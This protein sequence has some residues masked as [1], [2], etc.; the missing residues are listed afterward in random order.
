MNFSI[1]VDHPIVELGAEKSFFPRVSLQGNTLFR[2]TTAHV[3]GPKMSDGSE[4]DVR[5]WNFRLE[6]K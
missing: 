5:T 6:S 1:G 2:A 4:H 3:Q